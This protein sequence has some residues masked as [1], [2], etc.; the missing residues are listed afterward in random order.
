MSKLW[1]GV[2]KKPIGLILVTIFLFVFLSNSAQALFVYID[3]NVYEVNETIA[4][5]VN[6]TQDANITGIVV[7]RTNGTQADNFTIVSDGTTGMIE[8]SYP[9]TLPPGE[10]TLTL[11][12]GSDSVQI[13]FK[14]VSEILKPVVRLMGSLEPIFINTSTEVRNETGGVGGN[15]SE[16]SM[17]MKYK[18]KRKV[19]NFIVHDKI[20]KTFALHSDN[21][22]VSATGAKI[23]IVENDPEYVFLYGEMNPGQEIVITYSVNQEVSASVINETETTVYGENYEVPPPEE[24]C[25]AGEKRCE[26]NELQECNEDRTGWL[27]IESCEYGCDP[28]KFTCKEAPYKQ[29]SPVTIGMGNYWMWI[30]VVVVII[31]VVVLG[32]VLAKRRKK[33][34]FKLPKPMTGM[35]TPS[36]EFA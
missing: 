10:Y 17:R 36:P 26:G 8:Y 31:V 16:L 7:Y 13:G 33:K 3:K 32:M 19:E 30:V 5:K 14:V 15:F 4:I 6:R 34:K 35:K 24:V 12:Q 28:E 22:T 23:E 25:K 18:G 29:T 21:V 9:Q 20:P 27:T 1:A 11:A 2:L